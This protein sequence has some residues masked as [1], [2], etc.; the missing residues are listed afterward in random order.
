[1]TVVPHL[2]LPFRISGGSPTCNEQ[3]T[4]ADVR[5]CVEAIV[6]TVQGQ[7]IELPDFGIPDETF[8]E[9]G[10]EPAEIQVA[11]QTWEPRAAAEAAANNESLDA[12]I[13]EITVDITGGAG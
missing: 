3:D 11:V 7:R 13:S 9:S 5:D 2:A 12:Y 4:A 6:R 10:A 1:M 8:T